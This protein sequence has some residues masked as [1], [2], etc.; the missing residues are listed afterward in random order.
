M[1]VFGWL[2]LMVEGVEVDDVI[3]MFVCEVEWYGMNV[4]V[5]IGDKDFV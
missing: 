4:I 1:C 5:L 3:G 2:L